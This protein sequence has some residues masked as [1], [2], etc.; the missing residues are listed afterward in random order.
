MVEMFRILQSGQKGF[1]QCWNIQMEVSYQN[2]VKGFISAKFINGTEIDPVKTYIGVTIDFLLKGGDDF[3]DVI[4]KTYTPQNE[5][6]KGDYKV[7]TEPL[8]KKMGVIK[9]GTLINPDQPRLIV[10]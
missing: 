10:R 8:L 1:Y 3:K 5:Q 6:D 2:L 4:N 7:I 9:A